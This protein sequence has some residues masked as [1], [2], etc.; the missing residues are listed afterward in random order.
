MLNLQNANTWNSENVASKE[1]KKKQSLHHLVKSLS[2]ACHYLDGI[3][4]PI[5]SRDFTGA[6]IL[7][8]HIYLQSP[9]C[10]QCE[11]GKHS[12][13]CQCEAGKH[14]KEWEAILP[15]LQLVYDMLS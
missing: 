12:K 8:S 13:Y 7:S 11:A 15:D 9:R 10:C 4:V 3:L 6:K 14:I 5:R 1:E 2:P